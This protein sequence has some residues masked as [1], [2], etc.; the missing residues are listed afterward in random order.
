M[1]DSYVCQGLLLSFLKPV[2]AHASRAEDAYRLQGADPAGL[3]QVGLMAFAGVPCQGP[4]DDLALIQ[5]RAQHLAGAL[6]SLDFPGPVQRQGDVGSGDAL[7]R[8]M[9]LTAAALAAMAKAACISAARPAA[10]ARPGTPGW[11][12]PVRWT[13]WP[14]RPRTCAATGP[15][16]T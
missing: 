8:T 1:D 15:R 2:E 7:I 10:P 9:R 13:R 11:C 12:C 14:R 16:A 6:S 3:V 4:A 5:W